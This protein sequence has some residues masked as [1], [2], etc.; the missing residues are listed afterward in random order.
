MAMRKTLSGEYQ[1]HIGRCFSTFIQYIIHLPLENVRSRQ[2]YW[3]EH[4]RSMAVIISGT[5]CHVIPRERTTKYGINH[6][7]YSSYNI[8]HP[9]GSLHGLQGLLTGVWLFKACCKTH[10]SS[11]PEISKDSC[12]EMNLQYKAI[13]MAGQ[14]NLL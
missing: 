10:F 12:I 6:K 14:L 2:Q 1:S 11:Y 9:I 8:N 3:R 7:S 13:I 5:C 4:S